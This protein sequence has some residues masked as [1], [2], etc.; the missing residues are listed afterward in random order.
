MTNGHTNF[1]PPIGQSFG[2]QFQIE[3]ALRNSEK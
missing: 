3:S 1:Q 2:K